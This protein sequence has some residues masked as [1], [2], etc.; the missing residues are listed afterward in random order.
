M[1]MKLFIVGLVLGGVIGYYGP[2]FCAKKTGNVV[3][4]VMHGTGNVIGSI[5]K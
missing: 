3:A 1:K 4:S 5:A 2:V